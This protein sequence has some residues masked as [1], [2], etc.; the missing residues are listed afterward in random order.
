MVNRGR[1][2]SILPEVDLSG[3]DDGSFAAGMAHYAPLVKEQVEK[4]DHSYC[5]PSVQRIS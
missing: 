4:E 5:C 2:L 3:E 1:T